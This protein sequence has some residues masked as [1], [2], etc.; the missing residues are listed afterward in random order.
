MINKL[1]SPINYLRQKQ[2]RDN[3]INLTKL[4]N[5]TVDFKE[6]CTRKNLLKQGPTQ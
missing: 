2:S 3:F 6:K 1:P 5:Q 4:L